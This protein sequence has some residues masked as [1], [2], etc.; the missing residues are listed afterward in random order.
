MVFFE[1]NA[2]DVTAEDLLQLEDRYKVVQ[3]AVNASHVEDTI[4]R[5]ERVVEKQQEDLT[6]YDY[7]IK[8]LRNDIEN[9]EDIKATLPQAC[10]KSATVEQP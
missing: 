1:D 10:S 9:L 6:L 4:S 7:Q 3:D 5:L 2:P 8:L